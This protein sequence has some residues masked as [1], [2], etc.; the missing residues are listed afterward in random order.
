MLPTNQPTN[1]KKE[2]C[3]IDSDSD[4]NSEWPQ[5]LGIVAGRTG[6]WMRNR[7]HRIYSIVKN[8]QNTKKCSRDVERVAITQTPVEDHQL[9]LVLGTLNRHH[10]YN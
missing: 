2:S 9:T 7:D 10:F 1:L 4:S 3:K 8:G 5:R 6:N